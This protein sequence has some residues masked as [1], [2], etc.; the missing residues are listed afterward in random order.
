MAVTN[1]DNQSDRLKN[2]LEKFFISSFKTHKRKGYCI[3]RDVM[4]VLLDK[5]SLLVLYN[6]AYYDTLRFGEIRSNIKDVSSR[7]LSVTL[8]KLEEHDLVIR[9]SYN[10]VPPKVEYSLSQLGIELA[11]KSL[12]LNKWFLEKFVSS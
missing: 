5:W 4:S 2:E 12:D 7:M 8:K 1:I 6:L 3:T 9:K 10:E 11:D